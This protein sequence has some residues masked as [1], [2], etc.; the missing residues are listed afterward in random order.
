[1][2]TLKNN[3]WTLFGL[4]LVLT[5]ALT[6]DAS[7]QSGDLMGLARNKA[8]NVFKSVKTIIFVVGGFGL[9]GLAFQAIFGK[10]KWIWFGSLAVGLAVLAAAGSVVNYATGDQTTGSDSGGFNDTFSQ[11]A[12][13]SI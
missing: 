12:N 1:M 5:V 8:V 9:V 6:G 11:S 3:F 10:I 4:A 13:G 2:K 7:A